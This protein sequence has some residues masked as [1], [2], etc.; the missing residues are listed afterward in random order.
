M[1]LFFSSLF[2]FVFFFT[3]GVRLE[4]CAGSERKALKKKRSI[5]SSFAQLHCYENCFNLND[6]SYNCQQVEKASTVDTIESSSSA[7][8]RIS[9][10]VP[11]TVNPLV[12]SPA[13]TWVPGHQHSRSRGGQD[14]RAADLMA[15][16]QLLIST[17]K[18]L[19]QVGFNYIHIHLAHT[20]AK[21]SPWS[22]QIERFNKQ[23]LQ[24]I[25]SLRAQKEDE[26]V[27]LQNLEKEKAAMQE[28]LDAV[29]SKK[30]K[31]QVA[32]FAITF[33]PSLREIFSTLVTSS[34]I[35]HHQ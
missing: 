28:L 34:S 7:N 2:K 9:S 11:T 20:Q 33:R 31:E 35:R 22:I 15:H 25:C 32:S 26:K 18:K 3:A 21:P 5:L 29:R 17:Q 1:R 6:P 8:K 14:V 10:T 30:E 12:S 13:A 24:D 23:R 27:E 16:L 19:E 4:Y